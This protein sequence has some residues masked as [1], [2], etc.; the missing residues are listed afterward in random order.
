MP[1]ACNSKNLQDTH[2]TDRGP[3]G[4]HRHS[5]TRAKNPLIP[6]RLSY[7]EPWKSDTR[8]VLAIRLDSGKQPHPLGGRIR[9]DTTSLVEVPP[10]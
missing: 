9:R 7:G 4:L 10:H 6:A 5:P 1:K 8:Q 3:T 2:S